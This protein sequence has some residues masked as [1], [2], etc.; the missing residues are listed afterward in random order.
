MP[1]KKSAERRM[2]S[3]AR[4]QTRN[5]AAK[6]R[7]KTAEKQFLDAVAQGKK[8]EASTAYRQV[9]SVYDKAAKGGALHKAKASRKKS[10]LAARLAGMK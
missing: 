2:R 5:L 10:R 6:S 7:V 9:S 3:S 8:E 4:A 1:N